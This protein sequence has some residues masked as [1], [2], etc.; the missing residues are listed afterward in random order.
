MGAGNYVNKDRGKPCI[1]I[2]MGAEFLVTENKVCVCV[3]GV[4]GMLLFVY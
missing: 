3:C 1:R 2:T 4:N